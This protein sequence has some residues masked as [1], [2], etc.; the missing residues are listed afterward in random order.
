MPLGL[1]G[2]TFDPPHRGHLALGEAARRQLGLARVRL[3]PAG[4]PWR[5]AARAVAPAAERL[6]MTR[7][8]TADDPAFEVDAREVERPGPSYT[9]DTLRELRAG[10]ETDLV[11]ILGSDAL[12]DLPAWREPEAIVAL[13]RLAVAARAGEPVKAVAARAGEPVKAPAGARVTA[14][15]M[16]PLAIS[17][18]LVRERI[19]AGEP[20]DDLLPVAVADYVRARGL[21]R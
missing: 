8:A 21:Y 19:R 5:K 17:S 3:L 16:P 7:L 18:T 2:G 1:L 14:L 20:V 12:A 4:D 15:A 10:G 6:A 9:V 13:A 11:L